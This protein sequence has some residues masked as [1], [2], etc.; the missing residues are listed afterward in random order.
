MSSG[1]KAESWASWTVF[2]LPPTCQGLR[3][4]TDNYGYAALVNCFPLEGLR[5]LES[6]NCFPCHTDEANGQVPSSLCASVTEPGM[7]HRVKFLN[8][9][10]VTW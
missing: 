5:A 7:E 8:G 9:A 4:G 3:V 2:Q 6:E 10:Q 1:L